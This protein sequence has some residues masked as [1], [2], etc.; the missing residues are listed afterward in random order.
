MKQLGFAPEALRDLRD[1]AGYIAEDNPDRAM[2]FVAEL[3]AKAAEAAAR[4]DSFRERR[5]LSP[6]LRAIG[7]GRY[8][9]FFRNLTDEVRIVRVV[10]GTRDL[11]RVF[12]R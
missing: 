10:H 9:I 2:T 11:Q 3:E 5:D 4:P 6:G 8:I 12:D 7:H 1:I